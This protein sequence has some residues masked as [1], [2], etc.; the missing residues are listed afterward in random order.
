MAKETLRNSNWASLDTLVFSKVMS[1][2]SFH[3]KLHCEA[4][5][6]AWR[7]SLTTSPAPGVWGQLWYLRWARIKRARMELIAGD[8][9][10]SLPA[11]APKRN[12]STVDWLSKRAVGVQTLKLGYHIEGQKQRTITYDILMNGRLL[13]LLAG[14]E[15]A[16][17]ASIHLDLDGM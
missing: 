2:T 13:E 7:F 1:A 9:V 6:K 15:V 8:R 12:Y 5:C 11:P 17:A 3:N 10:I 14:L 16:G 4:V